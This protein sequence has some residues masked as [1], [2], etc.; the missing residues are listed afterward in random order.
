MLTT[1]RPS[2]NPVIPWGLNDSFP[3][4]DVIDLPRFSHETR[5]LTAEWAD[6]QDSRLSPS[7]CVHRYFDYLRLVEANLKDEHLLCFEELFLWHELRFRNGQ[8]A[9]LD[10]PLDWLDPVW[11][12]VGAHLHFRPEYTRLADELLRQTL[13]SST[14]RAFGGPER[15]RL[16]PCSFHLGACAP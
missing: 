2:I 7:E 15:R 11:D 6:V 14:K 9:V 3:L 5:I 13:G 8:G 12:S 16:T 10:A 4:G 1:H